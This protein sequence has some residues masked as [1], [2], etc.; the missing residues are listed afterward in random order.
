MMSGSGRWLTGTMS[1]EVGKKKEGSVIIPEGEWGG[2][3]NV[4]EGV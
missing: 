3:D 4:A 1:S 2:D